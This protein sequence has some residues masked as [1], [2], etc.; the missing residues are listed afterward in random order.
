MLKSEKLQLERRLYFPRPPVREMSK[1]LIYRSPPMGSKA[2]T[3][4]KILLGCDVLHSYFLPGALTRILRGIKASIPKIHKTHEQTRRLSTSI[5]C[6]Y[7]I[8]FSIWPRPLSWDLLQQ[9]NNLRATPNRRKQT[10]LD[11]PIDRGPVGPRVDLFKGLSIIRPGNEHHALRSQLCFEKQMELER[12][13]ESARMGPPVPETL[14]RTTERQTAM[15]RA[16]HI[17]R[18]ATMCAPGD[19]TGQIQNGWQNLENTT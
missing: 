1:L 16:K 14:H 5:L 17:A 11:R 8:R 19:R 3:R 2:L 9:A 10:L 4:T 18:Y 7:G 6:L 15:R 12:Y 13:K